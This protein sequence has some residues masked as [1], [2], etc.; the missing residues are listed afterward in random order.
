[1]AVDHHLCKL[2]DLAAVARPTS[3]AADR[4]PGVASPGIEVSTPKIH[5]RTGRPG[6]ASAGTQIAGEGMTLPLNIPNEVTCMRKKTTPRD[7]RVADYFQLLEL[8]SQRPLP[9]VCSIQEDIHRILALRSA[10]LV[11]AL[12]E[13]PEQ[14]R[15]GERRIARAVVTAIT[16]EGRNALARNARTARGAQSAPSA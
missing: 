8:L 7:R 15:S 16:P 3:A 11:E 6:T 9:V 4:P 5:R 13:P 14:L 10:S 1:M 12:T 2:L